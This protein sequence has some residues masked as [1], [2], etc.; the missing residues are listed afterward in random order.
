[1][2][3]LNISLLQEKFTITDNSGETVLPLVIASNRVVFSVGE[4]ASVDNVVVRSKHGYV[5]MLLCV[6]ILK[7]YFDN[8][9]FTGRALPFDWGG[10]WNST[11][12]IYDRKYNGD[13]WGVIYINGNPVFKQNAP[14]FIDVI[15]KCALLVKENYESVPETL[16]TMLK[17][18]GNDRSVDYVF[19]TVATVQ[20]MGDKLSCGIVSF[21]H[22]EKNAFLF[23]FSGGVKRN[24][25][26]IQSVM[27]CAAYLEAS[28][29][30]GFIR[31]DKGK[32]RRRASDAVSRKYAVQKFVKGIE[33]KYK[34]EYF[35][36]KPE[37]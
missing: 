5:A 30:E 10:L 18:S 36:F 19:D 8:G 31:R 2:D 4:K 12:S 27:T 23:D 24:E 35:P 3:G 37:F 29:L 26:F 21:N 15:E 28:W 22:D 11:I 34:I 20:N 33:G 32:N 25:R 13:I 17:K 7:E 14:T 1:M 6:K 9:V 16:Q